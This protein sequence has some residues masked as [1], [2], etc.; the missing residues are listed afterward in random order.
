MTPGCLGHDRRVEKRFRFCGCPC[1]LYW[2]EI[3]DPE[4]D[5][6]CP[7]CKE[8]KNGLS[9]IVVWDDGEDHPEIDPEEG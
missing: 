1:G 5:P 9:S 2:D 3:N 8:G 4:K 6:E 7:E